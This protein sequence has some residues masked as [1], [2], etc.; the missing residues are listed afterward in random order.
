MLEAD[1]REAQVEP[2]LEAPLDQRV[3]ALEAPQAVDTEVDMADIDHHTA[4]TD[5]MF[6]STITLDLMVMLL[7]FLEAWDMDNTTTI[8]FMERESLIQ[9]TVI[10]HHQAIWAFSAL[11][12]ASAV[13]S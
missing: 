12:A 7:S 6:Q 11:S 2:Q 13:S 8:M 1:H 3:A 10:I 4:A 9:I 5:H